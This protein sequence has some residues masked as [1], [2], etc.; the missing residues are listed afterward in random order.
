MANVRHQA[1]DKQRMHQATDRVG[2]FDLHLRKGI[3]F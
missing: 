2:C 3:L 1:L